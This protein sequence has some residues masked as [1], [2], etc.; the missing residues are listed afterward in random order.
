MEVQYS[1]FAFPLEES[2]EFVVIL[3]KIKYDKNNQRH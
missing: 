1:A 3:N 2:N